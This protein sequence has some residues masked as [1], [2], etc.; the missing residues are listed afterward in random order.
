MLRAVLPSVY[1]EHFS[2]NEFRYR[3]AD[4]ISIDPAPSARMHH[5]A[6]T[7][8]MRNFNGYGSA[9]PSIPTIASGMHVSETTARAAIQDLSEAG[10]L[11]IHERQGQTHMFQALL[12]PSCVPTIVDLATQ[13]HRTLETG[14]DVLTVAH[15]TAGVLLNVLGGDPADHKAF[16][17]IRAQI[18][19]IL[20][21]AYDTEGEARYL[22]KYVL[23]EVPQQIRNPIGLCHSRLGEYY[24]KF[25]RNRKRPELVNVDPERKAFVQEVLNR[26]V[27]TL[28]RKW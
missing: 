28:G 8:A 2:L 6:M 9:Y 26:L 1:F 16:I 7:I 27:E 14:P 13:R 10:W 24:R 18:A 20:N 11:H 17:R 23:D 12:P 21:S 22:I 4:I 5:A 15:H 19:S 3:W 25:A